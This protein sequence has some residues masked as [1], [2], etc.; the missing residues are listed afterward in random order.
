MD[1]TRDSGRDAL[2][3]AL[4]EVSGLNARDY[5]LLGKVFEGKN[6]KQ[7]AIETHLAHDTVKSHLARPAFKAAVTRMR[8][9][10]LARIMDGEFGTMTMAK[11]EAPQA[12]A[13]IIEISRTEANARIRLDANVKVLEY[14]GLQPP[15]PVAEERPERLI[16][17]M[18]AQEAEHFITTGEFPERMRAQLARVTV[19]S[20]K[21]ADPLNANPVVEEEDV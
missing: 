7:I 12:M 4:P 8:E 21:K 10:I 3:A 11:N 17:Q 18:S 5:I 2:G 15:K 20:L 13:R 16:D 6:A 1:L 19:A 9:A 14:A